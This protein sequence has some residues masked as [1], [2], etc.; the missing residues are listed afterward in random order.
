M[1]KKIIGTA[2]FL[3]K[4]AVPIIEKIPL[5]PVRP[6]APQANINANSLYIFY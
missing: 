6:L 5:E 2:I 1:L 4:I 3:K